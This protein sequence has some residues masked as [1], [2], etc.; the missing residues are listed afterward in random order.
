ML[1]GTIETH[2]EIHIDR[3]PY[4]S[5][6]PTTGAALYALADI[7]HHA[8]L[9]REAAGDQ[10]DQLVPRNES[11]VV[12]TANEHF[13][14]QRVTTIIVNAEEKEVTKRRLSFNDLIK[15]AFPVPPTGANLMFT[16][17]YRNGPPENPKGHLLEGQSV[18]VK[19]GMIF[20]VTATDRS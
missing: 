14:S 11:P 5:P 15:L 2:I 17:A 10:E 6:N 19:N 8:D 12:L 9:F 13:Y 4:R 18:Y 20:D 3:E 16:I 1:D 7:P